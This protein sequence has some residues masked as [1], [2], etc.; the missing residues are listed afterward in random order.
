MGSRPW[1]A[2]DRTPAARRLLAL[3]QV[4]AD[5]PERNVWV[6]IAIADQW[7]TTLG[8]AGL[9][10]ALE[11]ATRFALPPPRE[12][13]LREIIEVPARR[14]GLAF[15]PGRTG[16]RWTKKSSTIWRDCRCTPRRRCHYCKW[17]WH[18]WKTARTATS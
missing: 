3:L 18:S 1:P 6:A 17:P 15:E 13:E 11:G 16:R 7:R 5:C 14:A 4:L 8:S 10:A 2:T 9:A 12:G